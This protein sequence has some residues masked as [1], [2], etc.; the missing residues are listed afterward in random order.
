[1]DAAHDA[2]Q[3][4]RIQE[5]DDCRGTI[6]G[7]TIANFSPDRQ[8]LAYESTETGEKAIAGDAIRGGVQ[9]SAQASASAAISD[10]IFSTAH[11]L[12]AGAK[13]P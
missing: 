6:D 10:S 11:L 4:K 3:Y 5:I 13:L 12:L 2:A 8:W 9:Q 1:L 7:L